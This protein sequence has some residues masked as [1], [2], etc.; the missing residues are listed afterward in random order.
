MKPPKSWKAAYE[1]DLALAVRDHIKTS[2][3]G[4]AYHNWGHIQQVLWHAE[5]TYE[6]PFDLALCKAILTHDV[7][8]DAEPDKEL[9]SAQWLMDNDTKG[10]STWEAVQ[11]IMKTVDHRITDDNRMVLCDLG[12]MMHPRWTANNFSKIFVESQTLYK[13]GPKEIAEAS[14]E[15]MDK[16]RNQY[17]DNKIQACTPHDRLAFYAIRAGIER[18]MIMYDQMIEAQKRA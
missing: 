3:A 9:R 10:D 7:I 11:H 15:V 14:L 18:C 2:D 17:A 8:Y 12:D 16:L 13:R 5:Y 1:C 6:Y 4:R